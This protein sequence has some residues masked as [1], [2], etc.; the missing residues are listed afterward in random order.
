M[1][2]EFNTSG[3]AFEDYGNEEVK[4]IL[5]IGRN[6]LQL[7]LRSNSKFRILELVKKIIQKSHD[8]FSL[9]LLY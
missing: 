3:Q 1:K 2:I 5:E 4:R 6:G 8:K 9:W 7:L